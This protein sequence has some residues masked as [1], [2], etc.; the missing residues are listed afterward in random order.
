M[1]S[2]GEWIERLELVA[3]VG[4]WNDQT[5]LVNVATRLRGSAAR[6]YRSCLPQ[7][8][9][10]YA[11]LTAALRERFTPVRLQ[12]VQS[13]MFH[14]RKQRQNPS[15]TVDTY[16]QELRKL[17]HRAY[18]TAQQEEGGIGEN[19]LAYQFVAGLI[20]PLKAK[21]V[22]TKGT[23]EEL[24]TKARF[25]EARRKE[26]EKSSSRHTAPTTVNRNSG[27]KNSS[28][29]T[30]P[31]QS[32]R[33]CFSCGGIGHLAW[34]CSLKGRGAPVESRGRGSARGTG[35]GGS[36]SFSNNRD[37]QVSMLQAEVEAGTDVEA[38]E[39]ELESEH[40]VTLPKDINE[41]MATDC[42][43]NVIEEA[44]SHVMATM[45][46]VKASRD[47]A[48]LGPTSTT[49][50]LLDD[51]PVR[52]LLDTGSPTSIVS[53]EF[54]LRAAATRRTQEQ[55]PAD[56]GKAIQQRLHPTTI[57]LRSYGGSELQIV[58]QVRCRIAWQERV[59]DAVLQV[60]KAAPVDLLLGTDVL[61]R[62]GFALVRVGPQASEDLLSCPP[63]HLETSGS[64]IP[65][66]EAAALPNRKPTSDLVLPTQTASQGAV[67]SASVRL[68]QATKLPGRHSRLIQA[69]VQ[70]N[71]I[72]GTTLLF[73][74]DK[75]VLGAKGVSV[76]DA[77]VAPGKTV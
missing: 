28:S 11:E 65:A 44:I 7:K 1:E 46:G 42:K 68:I 67:R 38:T 33:R 73:E 23:F 37:T 5:K 34:N 50:M 49:E 66:Q 36:R 15:E 70:D 18:P 10:N 64:R 4:R 60:Q 9:S 26:R 48:K 57:S 59:V 63:L 6:F 2:F 45:Y 47:T 54:F 77:V 22:G 76:A 72:A 14:E 3:N 69:N 31:P 39:P 41:E 53:L 13:S 43:T 25:E 75:E 19:V 40:G 20:D 62:L 30:T 51:V 12:S 17:F 71:E 55:T 35:R 74:P 58:S 16:A 27:P 52:A 29:R 56:W 21:L 8:R 32:D 61:P 24:L